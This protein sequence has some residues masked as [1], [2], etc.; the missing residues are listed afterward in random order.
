MVYP[1]EGE[2][3]G[4]LPGDYPEEKRA[5]PMQEMPW[6]T[7]DAFGLRAAQLAGKNSFETFVG[8]HIRFD[9]KQLLEWLH[10]YFD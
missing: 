1:R 6:Y 4:G 8:E 5:V 3:W 10:K 7:T 9:E 2:Q